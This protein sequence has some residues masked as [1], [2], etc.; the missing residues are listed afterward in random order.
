MVEKPGTGASAVSTYMFDTN[1]NHLQ[2]VDNDSI[3]KGYRLFCLISPLSFSCGNLVPALFSASGRVTLVGRPSGGGA[4]AVYPISTADGFF[5]SISGNSR[6]STMKNGILYSVDQGVMPDIAVTEISHLYDRAY[7]TE[8]L[9]T[10][11]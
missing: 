10:L 8:Y 9:N 5:L 7:L 3:S 2:D 4:C 6:L 11:P 1:L